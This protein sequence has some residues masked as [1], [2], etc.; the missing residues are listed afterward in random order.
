VQRQLLSLGYDVGDVD[1]LIGPR[2][3]A[4]TKAFQKDNDLRASGLPDE[5]TR[6]ELSVRSQFSKRAE[7]EVYVR[8]GGREIYAGPV[9]LVRPDEPLGTHLYTMVDFKEDSRSADW[10]AVTLQAKGRLPGWTQTEWRKRA[11]DIAAV[12][13]GQAIGRLRFPEHVRQT[14]EDRL[15]PGS[16]LIIADSGS[17]RETGV[18]TDFIVLTD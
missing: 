11:P 3:V 14:I 1:G 6:A 2:M 13:A 5:A 7:G 17:E 9:E 16:S 8:Q 12:D 4:A 10:L 18:L 15:T